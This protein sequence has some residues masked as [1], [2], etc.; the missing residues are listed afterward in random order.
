MIQFKNVEFT[1]R[2]P[3]TYDYHC[4]LLS[5]PLGSE[6]STIYGVTTESPLNDI[7][8]FHVIGQLPQDVLLEGVIPD[9]LRLVLSD[10]ITVKR[11]YTLDTLNERIACF[12]YAPQESSDKP[13]MITLNGLRGE[14]SLKQ[15]CKLH[16]CKW[17]WE[18][19]TNYCVYFSFTDVGFG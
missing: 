6:S 7:K 14:S 12:C 15:S 1:P 3:E 8:H 11:L 13:T 19:L 4:S 9:E 17:L 16:K 5:G 10:H 18:F 2:T